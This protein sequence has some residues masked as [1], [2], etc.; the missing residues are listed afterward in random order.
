MQNLYVCYT[1]IFNHLEKIFWSNILRSQ[2]RGSFFIIGLQADEI[3]LCGEAGAINL[4]EEICNTTGEEMEV[5][6]VNN[7]NAPMTCKSQQN[8]K[9][10]FYSGADIQKI[11][12]V[13]SGRFRARVSG[14]RNAGRLYSV[15]Q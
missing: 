7:K 10:S 14:P 4:I 9:V 13:E 2:L 5:S 1:L 12:G 3:H 11:N 6:Y 8:I 15:F